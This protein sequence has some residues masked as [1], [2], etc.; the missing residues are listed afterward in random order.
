VLFVI[1]PAQRAGAGRGTANRRLRNRI[2]LTA[3]PLAC[4]DTGADSSGSWVLHSA[5][6][7][8]TWLA[9]LPSAANAPDGIF[10]AG[11]GAAL[12]PVGGSLWRSTDGGRSWR[13]SWPA[14]HSPAVVPSP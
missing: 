1:R 7:G 6:G 10:A 4:N 12:M 11:V 9:R 2:G 13:E 8:S 14:L 3:V 5:D